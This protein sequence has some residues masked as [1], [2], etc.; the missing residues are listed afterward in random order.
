LPESGPHL[1]SGA[2]ALESQLQSL[3]T[4]SDDTSWVWTNALKTSEG[5]PQNCR[6]SK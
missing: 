1:F 2:V 6:S 3:D 5:K 4:P